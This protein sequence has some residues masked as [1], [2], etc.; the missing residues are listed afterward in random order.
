[1]KK[2]FIIGFDGGPYKEIK[3]WIEKGELPF[4]SKMAK[5]GAFGKLKSVIPPFTMLA[6]PIIF[7]GKNPAKIGPFLYK[8]KKKGF[9]PEFFSEAQLINSTDIRTWSIWEWVSHFDGKVGIM[10]VPMTYPPKKVNG[11][12]ITGALTPKNA[13]NFTY[14]ENLKE[15]MRDYII[16]LEFS[17]GV[18]KVDK[19]LNKKKLRKNFEVLSGNRRKTALNLLGKYNPDFFMINF[20]ELDDFMHYF[21]DDK[22]AT[23][24]YL[25]KTDETAAAIYEQQKPDYIL[26]VSDHG[27]SRAP[28]KYFYINQYLLD[29][30]Y[31]KKSKNVSGKFFNVIYRMGIAIV[32]KFSFVRNLFSEKIKLRVVRG[33]VKEQID[34]EQ[35]HAYAHWYAGLYLNPKFYPDEE[36]KKKGAEELK[37]VLLEAKDPENGER[38]I[39]TA[40]TKWEMFRGEFFD[41]MPEVVYTTTEDYRLNTNLP[42]KLVDKRVDRPS[43]VGHHTSA[44]DGI[45]FAMGKGIKKGSRI[46]AR[47]HDVFP[48]ACVLG[49]LPVPEDSDGK[50]LE[51]IIEKNAFKVDF[52]DIKYNKKDKVAHFLTAEEDETVKE[53]LK[54]L[55]YL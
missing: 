3:E 30:G 37:N 22:E 53:H 6:W 54:D 18:G 5:E 52:S 14:P 28:S 8:S 45:L 55:G 23:L 43:L 36:S 34:W 47:I 12:F 25:K 38:M 44:L 2:V 27:F 13:E 51:E 17:E 20:K 33:S 41:E 40:K 15:D 39:L 49:G 35:T 19:S 16:D 26:V 50:V 4:L 7:T 29:K 42:G 46:E 31:L 48:T 10:N 9:D 32:K 11:F 24:D 21:W 1:M